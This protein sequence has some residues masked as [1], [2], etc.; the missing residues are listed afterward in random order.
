MASPLRILYAS[1]EVVP[2]A[3]TG[4]LADVAGALPKV[5]ADMGH[6][7]RIVMPRYESID[8]ERYGL[9]QETAPFEILHGNGTIT[10]SVERSDAIPG[11]PTYFIRNDDLYARDS[12]YGQPD[13]DHRFIAYCRGMLE[14]L[15]ILEWMP[16][17]INCNDWHTS[18]TPVYLKTLYADDANY[19]CIGSL[20]SIHNL[21]Y[22]GD[23]SPQFM[24]L[25][26]LPWELFTWDKLAFNDRFNCMKAALIYADKLSTVSESYAREIQTPEFGEGLEGVLQYRADDLSGILNGI[27]YAV[28]NPETDTHIEQNYSSQ[29]HTRKQADKR[30]LQKAMGLPRWDNAPLFGIVSR[31]SSQKG[32]DLLDAILP[33]LLTAQ[34]MQVVILGS[35]D[36][37]YEEMFDRLSKK[38]PQ[39]LAIA[40][41][42]DE[43][44]AHA[45]YAGADAFLMPSRYE[46][47]GLGQ[48][49]SLAYGTLPLV[50]TV[51]GLAD[52]IQEIKTIRGKGN[53]FTFDEYA[54]E[55]FVA[56]MQRAIHCYQEK[57]D[58]WT[59]G[60]NNAFACHFSWAISAQ[61][62]L[63]IYKE[64]IRT[65]RSGVEMLQS[66][67]A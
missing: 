59:R 45:I 42:F 16:D 8:G 50:H 1:A 15:P 62:Y 43:G 33:S 64:A 31:L 24:E 67:S 41:R 57:R 54:S 60:M 12:L 52:T 9:R 28:W 2:Y 23:F 48:M 40:L 4:G 37:Y 10:I 3:K 47:C 38:Y 36:P 21:A 18:L 19:S 7:V 65:R 63:K 53:G 6:D 13:D 11:V 49:I 35:G 55:S 17:V 22:Q 32:F 14:M 29:K 51:G 58:C 61:K 39:K 46:P 66:M 25:A 34:K 30:A 20:Y 27:D 44:L 26:G 5:L 56:A